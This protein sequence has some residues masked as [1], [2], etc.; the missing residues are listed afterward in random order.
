MTKDEA[1]KLALDWLESGT[2]VYPT[3]LSTAI[4]E[5]LAQ[6]EQPQQEPV[7]WM[8]N[9]FDGDVCERSNHDDCENP[10]PLY[11]TPPKRQPLTYEEITAIS[12]QVA[13]AGP[14]GS[15]DRF[16]RAIE[17]AHDIKDQP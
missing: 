3:A 6:P 14:R 15:I 13:E 10:I 7:A 4:K 2:F 5:A 16:A 9:A 12:K 1:L 11:T 8:C 17:A